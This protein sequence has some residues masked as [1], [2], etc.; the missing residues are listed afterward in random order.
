MSSEKIVAQRIGQ[1][2]TFTDKFEAFREHSSCCVGTEARLTASAR[3]MSWAVGLL[4]KPLRSPK[5]FGYR[6]LI[7]SG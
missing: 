2:E 1:V 6:P 7:K 4:Q 3:P 5:S